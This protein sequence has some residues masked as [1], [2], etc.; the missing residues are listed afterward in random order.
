VILKSVHDAGTTIEPT[1]YWIASLASI[2]VLQLLTVAG[3]L[4]LLAMAPEAMPDVPAVPG[5][6]AAPAVVVAAGAV[7]IGIA[8][9]V[10]AGIGAVAPGAASFPDWL[11]P[12]PQAESTSVQATTSAGIFRFIVRSP[13]LKVALSGRNVPRHVK[14]DVVRH[15]G[16]ITSARHA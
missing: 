12:P 9:A 1:L 10:V 8:G 5:I 11:L 2:S 16:P 4:P 7:V 3:G 14:A 6:A 13:W 15:H